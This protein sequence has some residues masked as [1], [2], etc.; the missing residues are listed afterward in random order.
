M[1]VYGCFVFPGKL[2][3]ESLFSPARKGKR[4]GM[5]QACLTNLNQK[6]YASSK[7][8][9][10][11]GKSSSTQKSGKWHYGFLVTGH[12]SLQE[13][14][15]QE[16]RRTYC[17]ITVNNQLIL[18]QASHESRNL[19]SHKLQ[20]SVVPFLDFWDCFW[21]PKSIPKYRGKR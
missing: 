5:D 18:T 11:A 1:D 13:C 8:I 19:V 15:A 20:S 6:C 14:G 9:T 17:I 16:Q 21:K 2:R 3:M 7:L 10:L 12:V 4:K